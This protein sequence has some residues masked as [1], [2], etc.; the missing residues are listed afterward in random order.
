MGEPTD[1]GSEMFGHGLRYD[2]AL[3]HARFLRARW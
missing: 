1:G 3:P 2:R